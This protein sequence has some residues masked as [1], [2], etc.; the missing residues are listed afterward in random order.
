M[1][2]QYVYPWI[3]CK[4]QVV[5]NNM[6]PI[7]WYFIF[8]WVMDGIMWYFKQYILLMVGLLM[9]QL[10]MKFQYTN[11]NWTYMVYVHYYSQKV[12]TISMC[13][14]GWVLEPLL[15]VFVV[16]FGSILR[17]KFIRSKDKIICGSV[18]FWMTALKIWSN[19][20]NVV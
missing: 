7:M 19:T 4:L 8:R 13:L 3:T 2:K 15:G 16:R 1:I 6:V 10:H 12:N 17:K 5:C 11:R 9:L 20:I 18:Q 14:S